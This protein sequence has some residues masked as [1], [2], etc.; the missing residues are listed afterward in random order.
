M[1][2]STEVINAADIVKVREEVPNSIRGR[3]TVAYLRNGETYEVMPGAEGIANACRPIIAAQPGFEFLQ[4][5]F[6]EEANAACCWRTPII[7]WR[8]LAFGEPEPITPEDN[9]MSNDTCIRYPDGRLSVPW[10]RN[11]DTEQEWLDA[12]TVEYQ[13]KKAVK[14]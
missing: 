8:V 3:K 2:V 14:K 11:Y 10:D 7:A 1:R 4:A 9:Q 5:W 13:S 6:D 12:M